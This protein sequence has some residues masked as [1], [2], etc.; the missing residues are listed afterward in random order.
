VAPAHQEEG[1]KGSRD[2]GIKG[3]DYQ[4]FTT[5]EAPPGAADPARLADDLLWSLAFCLSAYR[6]QHPDCTTADVLRAL[7]LLTMKLTDLATMIAAGAE[8]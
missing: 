4:A 8:L 2:R 7:Y 3:V 1:I 6:M 5:P